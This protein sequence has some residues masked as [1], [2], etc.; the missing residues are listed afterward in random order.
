L[1]IDYADGS[2]TEFVYDAMSRR[3]RVLERDEQGAVSSDKRLLWE[4]LGMVQERDAQLTV[5]KRYASHGV[6]L[7]D[8]SQWYYTRDHLGSV[9]QVTDEDQQVVETYTYDAYGVTTSSPPGGPNGQ[10]LAD[11]G[12]TGHYHHE[13]SSL[14]LALFRAYDAEL[15]V[16]ISEDPIQERGGINLYGYVG[17]GPLLGIDLFGLLVDASFDTATGVFTVT[18]RDTGESC[19]MN[20][21]SGG[22]PWGDP[23]PKGSYSILDHPNVDFLRLESDDASFGDDT[24]DATGRDKFR[25]HKPGRSIGCVT[26]RDQAGWEKVRDLIRKTKTTESTVESKSWNPFAPSTESVKN[27][28]NLQV[29]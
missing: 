19:S 10:R 3:V 5:V 15:G 24:H 1:A 26:A 8:G 28:G 18:D 23:I 9:R 21:Y 27:F 16:W 7:A 11:F 20:A 25:L 2:R 13:K 29:D 22:N 17:N 14:H 6:A 4:G 12:Y